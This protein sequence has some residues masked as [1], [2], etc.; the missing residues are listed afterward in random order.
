MKKTEKMTFIVKVIGTA[1]DCH[2]RE[3]MEQKYNKEICFRE[4]NWSCDNTDETDTEKL[5]REVMFTAFDFNHNR[6]VSNWTANMFSGADNYY[7]ES[8]SAVERIMYNEDINLRHLLW[9]QEELLPL[10]R[11]I[12]LGERSIVEHDNYII[13][14]EV[15]YEYDVFKKTAEPYEK[16]WLAWSKEGGFK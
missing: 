16:A 6:M 11:Y 2:Y 12:R 14:K 4:Y 1:L 15:G 5:M 9:D 13:H 10:I 3:K 7:F 8:S